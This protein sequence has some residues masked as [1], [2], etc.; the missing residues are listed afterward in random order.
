[1]ISARGQWYRNQR[2][3]GGGGD[4]RRYPGLADCLW[5][6]LSHLHWDQNLVHFY[7]YPETSYES[8]T[9]SERRALD[10]LDC[11][12]DTENDMNHDPWG[13]EPWGDYTST[14]DNE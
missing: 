1:M 8:L 9:F 6:S 3:Y 2:S 13:D 4:Y 7:P 5:T 14:S 11:Y 10:L 12:E